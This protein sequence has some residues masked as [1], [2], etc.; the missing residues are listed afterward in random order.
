[1]SVL[2]EQLND[3]TRLVDDSTTIK[4]LDNLDLL[5]KQ[6]S[7]EWVLSKLKRVIDTAIP[8]SG[9]VF[10]DDAS[11]GIKAIE[12][13]VGILGLNA[14]TKSISV[15]VRDNMDN[16]KRILETIEYKEY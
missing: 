3:I 7:A 15:N 1:M 16:V 5:S 2:L 4:R 12:K 6:M 14:P 11:V 9:T 8:D 13:V 10:T